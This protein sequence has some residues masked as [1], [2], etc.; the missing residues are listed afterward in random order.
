MCNHSQVSALR[1]LLNHNRYAHNKKPVF[2]EQALGSHMAE[3][4]SEVAEEV[5]EQQFGGGEK[6]LAL[7]GERKGG[8]RPVR[9]GSDVFR[10]T[11]NGGPGSTPGVKIGRQK[12]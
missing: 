6:R 7:G 3:P 11:R 1:A 10:D 4:V 8:G 5:R 12:I 2:E 9:A